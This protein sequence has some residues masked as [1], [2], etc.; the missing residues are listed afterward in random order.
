MTAGTGEAPAAQVDPAAGQDCGGVNTTSKETTIVLPWEAP[1]ATAA[2]GIVHAPAHN[3]PLKPGS[4]QT[5]LIAIA[6][7]GGDAASVLKNAG[8]TPAALENAAVA[9][10]KGDTAL[11]AKFNQAIKDIRANGTYDRI[12]KLYFDFDVYNGR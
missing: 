1:T 12:A 7:E 9:L 11:Q 2:K 5:L 6:K 10:R 8:V 3:T 4:R